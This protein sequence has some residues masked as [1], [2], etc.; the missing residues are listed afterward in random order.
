MRFDGNLFPNPVLGRSNDVAGKYE[1]L[2]PIVETGS[3]E[4]HNKT[5]VS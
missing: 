4:N 2:P 1:P 5:S 3:D